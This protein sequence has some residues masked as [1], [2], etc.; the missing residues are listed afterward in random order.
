MILMI[1]ENP[2][3]RDIIKRLSEEPNYP[4]QLS[5]DLSLGQQLVAKHLRIMEDAGMVTSSV[6]SSPYGPKRRIY[7]LNKNVSITLDVSTHF[8]KA[9]MV[10]FDSEPEREEISGA[11]ASL[12]DKMDKTLEKPKQSETITPFTNIISDIDNKLEALEN[13]RAILLYLRN[14]AMKEASRIVEMF[15]NSDTRRIIRFALDEH[16]VSV[17][18]IS[19]SLNLR[20]AVVRR[21]LLKLKKGFNI[22]VGFVDEEENEN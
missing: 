12:M 1:L 8:F 9:K 4:L 20:E 3:R 22:G 7:T 13:E 11:S 18:N 17:K 15:K 16:D 2:T 19:E 5:K 6:E 21:T 14:F 10:F